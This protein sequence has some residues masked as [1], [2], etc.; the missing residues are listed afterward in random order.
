M[1]ALKTGMF[2][3]GGFVV[4]AVGDEPASGVVGLG[5]DV[6]G[7]VLGDGDVEDVD[8]SVFGEVVVVVGVILF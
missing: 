1:V 8:D 5:V 4:W 6:S 2:C 3:Q 7:W